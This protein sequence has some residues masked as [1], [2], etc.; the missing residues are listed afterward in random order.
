MGRINS[1]LYTR[2]AGISVLY[3]Y[4]C[5]CLVGLFIIIGCVVDVYSG[6]WTGQ[7]QFSWPTETDEPVIC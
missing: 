4:Y 5:V 3:C 2:L 7:W 6:C 1:D